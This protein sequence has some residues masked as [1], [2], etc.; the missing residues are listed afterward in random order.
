MKYSVVFQQI[1]PCL[2]VKA[3][4]AISLLTYTVYISVGFLS[5]L[6]IG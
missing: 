3:M 2:N 6:Q 1:L 4:K 5:W